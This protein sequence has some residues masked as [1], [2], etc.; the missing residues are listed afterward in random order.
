MKRFRQ[1]LREAVNIH[2][3]NTLYA[4]LRSGKILTH[5]NA[6]NLEHRDAFPHLNFLG[7]GGDTSGKKETPIAWGRI[8]PREKQL[9][10]V[11][12]HGLNTPEGSSSGVLNKDINNRLQAIE[13]IEKQYPDHSIVVG[14]GG[15]GGSAK[16]LHGYDQH[17]ETLYNLM[18]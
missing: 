8:D 11:T 4:V 15:Y 7:R 10:I 16:I 14:G 13:H 9:H 18:N 2:P 12:E 1:F 17:R 5:E 3:T 6:R